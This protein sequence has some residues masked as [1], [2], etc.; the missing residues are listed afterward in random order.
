MM[1]WNRIGDTICLLRNNALRRGI[2]NEKDPNGIGR[3]R[4]AV[5][6]VPSN[7]LPLL[8]PSIRVPSNTIRSVHIH[9]VMSRGKYVYLLHFNIVILFFLCELQIQTLGRRNMF[10]YERVDLS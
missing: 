1:R 4:F 6:T 5:P 8:T 9:C 3:G 10:Q 7:T 2:K